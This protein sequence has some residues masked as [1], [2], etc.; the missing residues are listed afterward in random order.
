MKR[1]S[2]PPVGSALALPIASRRRFVQ[3]LAASG[4][5]LGSAASLAD[6]AWSQ[7][8]NAA[9]GSA[10]VLRGTEFELVIAESP[11]NFTGT[12][13][14]ATTINGSI[15]APTLYWREG[16]TITIRVTNR[17]TQATSIHWHGILLPFRMDGVPGISFPGIAPGE[18][19]MYRFRVQQGGT[20]WYHSHSGMQEQTGMYGA[21][22]IEPADGERIRA[23]RD[24]VVQLSDWTDE[25]PMR[26]L[27]K[28]K[29]QSDVY[30]FNQPTVVDFLRDVSHEGMRAALDKRQMWNEMRMNPTDLADLSTYALTYLINGIT[31][32]G[33]W[34]ALFRPGERVR[35]RVINGAANTFYDVRIPGLKLTVVQAAGFDGEPAVFRLEVVQCVRAAALGVL[36]AGRELEAVAG[37][38]AVVMVGRGYQGRRIARPLLQIVQRRV[39]VEV[40]EVLRVFRAAIVPRPRAADREAMEAEHVHDA[41]LR[42]AG[43][44]QVGALRHAGT[45]Q[46][47][48]V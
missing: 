7:N 1:H 3:G 14:V 11:V 42:D 26:V 30:N 37:H 21:I 13:R 5:L 22:V 29:V 48:A 45:H 38:H 36:A 39:G 15:P 47:A 12:A 35:L 32:A 9:T 4:V 17:L 20:Y 33:N 18:T 24:Y 16:D 6:R 40:L 31:P 43:A 28:L 2:F 44:E 8:G 10:P 27:A 34:T 23:N 25:D 41:H 46:E 19:F